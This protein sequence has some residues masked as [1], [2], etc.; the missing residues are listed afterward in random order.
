MV[1]AKEKFSCFDSID[2][3]IKFCDSDELYSDWSVSLVVESRINSVGVF[4][5]LCW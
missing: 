3:A 1:C 2:G 4:G 5:I